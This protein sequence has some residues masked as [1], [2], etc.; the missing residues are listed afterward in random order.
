MCGDGG[1]V[2]GDGGRGVVMECGDGGRGVVMEC[3]IVVMEVGVW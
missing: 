3:R 2:R 1:R